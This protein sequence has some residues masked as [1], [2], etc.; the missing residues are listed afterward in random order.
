MA[1][2]SAAFVVLSGERAVKTASQLRSDQADILLSTALLAASSVRT[3]E[4]PS[5]DSV[6]DQTDANRL[7]QAVIAEKL[8]VVLHT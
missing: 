1:K 8:R 6:P 4:L 5:N 3:S 7:F 2:L